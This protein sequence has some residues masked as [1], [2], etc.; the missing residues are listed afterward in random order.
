M[1]VCECNNLLVYAFC[2]EFVIQDPV[3]DSLFEKS[4]K[5]NINIINFE[6]G[7]M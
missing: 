4:L 5:K 2:Y 7:T 6:I 3:W 1:Y